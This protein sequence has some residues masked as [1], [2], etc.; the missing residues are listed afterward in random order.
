SF[1]D[2]CVQP[3]PMAA[4]SY[5]RVDWDIFDAVVSRHELSGQPLPRPSPRYD[6]AGALHVRPGAAPDRLQPPLCGA[7]QAAAGLYA[8]GHHLAGD[9]A[10]SHEAGGLPGR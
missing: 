7:V 4:W 3:T 9:H 5:S 6:V 1:I 2:H 8:A 10:V